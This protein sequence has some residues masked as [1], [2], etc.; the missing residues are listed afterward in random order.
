[1]RDMTTIQEALVAAHIADL[2]REAAAIRAERER[3]HLRE[4]AAAGANSDTNDRLAELPS[5]RVR[6][7]RRLVAFGEAI[8]GT[9][10]RTGGASGPM[11]AAFAGTDDPCGDGN[12]GLAP[13][14]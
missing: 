10:P 13:A 4:H 5:R 3:D 14:T 7:G 12:D 9:A 8:A 2:Q 6:I 11:P 1:M